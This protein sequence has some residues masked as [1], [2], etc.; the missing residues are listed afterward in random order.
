MS[1]SRRAVERIAATSD[2]AP[3]LGQPEAGEL[4]RRAPAGRA[5]AAS[6]PRRRSGAA[7]ASSARRGPRSACGRPPRRARSPR[8]RAPRRRSRARR[9]RSPRGST[10]PRMPSSAM[11]SISDMSSRWSMS[12]WT[13]TGRIR[14]STNARTVSW[15]RRC[16]PVSSKSIPQIYSDGTLSPRLAR[17]RADPGPGD[18]GGVQLVVGRA[19]HDHLAAAG[20]LDPRSPVRSLGLLFGH[21]RWRFAFLVG[22]AGWVLYIVA[23]RLAPLSLVQAVSAGGLALLAVLAQREEGDAAARAASGSASGSPSSGSSSSRSRSRAG[24][25]GAAPAPGSRSPAGSSPRSS[26]SAISIGPAALAPR[27]RRRLRHRRRDHVRRRRRR[28]EGG[29]A[30]RR[31]RSSSRCRSWPATGSPSR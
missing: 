5:S 10:I 21:R 30:R 7:R 19:A 6:A 27:A 12:F 13:A 28:D 31:S 11:P 29:G 17:P 2:P 9:R 1:P 25:A 24:R 14:S 15:I 4:R 20:A 23:L 16:S 8:R 3:G 26:R 22:I 18:R